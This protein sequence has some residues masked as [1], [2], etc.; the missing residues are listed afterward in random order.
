L[1]KDQSYAA[2]ATGTIQSFSFSRSAAIQILAETGIVGLFA[3]LIIFFRGMYEAQALP[4]DVK[5]AAFSLFFY[6]LAAFIA[7]PPSIVLLFLL[8]I[9]LG[10][11]HHDIIAHSYRHAEKPFVKTI[12]I[13]VILSSMAA[14][15][16]F[17]ALSAG[18]YQM[19]MYYRADLA[20]RHSAQAIGN[21]S[22]SET[23]SDQ[24]NAITLNPY[25]EKYHI[26]FSQTNLYIANQIAINTKKSGSKLS[27][28]DQATVTNA[29]KTAIEESRAATVLNPQKASNWE[30][31][32]RIYKSLLT[33]AE[34]SDI[35]AIGAYERAGLLD[36]FNPVYKN[37]LGEVYYLTGQYKQAA[38]RFIEALHIKPDYSN[39]SYNLAWSY[40]QLGDKQKAI[41]QMETL[42]QS[43]R[44]ERDSDAYKKAI[45]DL[46]RLKK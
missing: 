32:G 45:S 44:T 5:I 33:V 27:S 34:K 4:R 2:S 39:A 28:R 15:V 8:A 7:F 25:Q 46:E 26:S 16:I 41:A 10:L 23:Y 12:K 6:L 22:L 42:S 40:Y 13:P 11:L 43:L 24:Y 1:A 3:F 30:N 14:V 37:D 20:Y 9:T 18:M 35:F 17:C 21:R 38:T 31:R 19:V 36:P 29:I